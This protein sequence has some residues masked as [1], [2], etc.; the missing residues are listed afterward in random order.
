MKYSGL[1]GGNVVRTTVPDKAESFPLDRIN[2]QFKVDRPHLCVSIF[3]LR[4]QLAG[5]A[6]RGLCDRCVCHAL[7]GLACE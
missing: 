2:H 5:L 7:R 4:Q 3:R 1:H 6:I